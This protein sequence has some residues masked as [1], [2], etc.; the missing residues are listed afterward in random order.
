MT[1]F[2]E[3][4]FAT[5]L[6]R[7]CQSASARFPDIEFE[8]YINGVK[9]KGHSCKGSASIYCLHADDTFSLRAYVVA[10]PA[11]SGTIEEVGRAIARHQEFLTALTYL[12]SRLDG[13][14]VKVEGLWEAEPEEDSTEQEEE[15]EDE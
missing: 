12:A 7:V 2:N 14:Q 3:E 1:P 11:L 10:M 9:I 8:P 6:Q 15:V 5:R 13:V 4:S